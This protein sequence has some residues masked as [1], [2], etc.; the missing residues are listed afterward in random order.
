MLI[1]LSLPWCTPR[2]A[3]DGVGKAANLLR[4]AAQ[5]HGFQAMV[6]VQVG[7]HRRHRQVVVV[8]LQAGD[9]LHQVAL[10]VVEHV[11]QAGDAVSRRV[12]VLAGTLQ[13]AA[14]Q[15]AHGF[16][17]GGIATVCDPVVELVRQ[18]VVER[19]REAFHGGALR[20]SVPR[21][22]PYT[23]PAASEAPTAPAGIASLI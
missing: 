2:S 11:R 6:V 3:H 18:L 13:F 12:V 8:V 23:R 15:V 16:G 1:R 17:A 20:R 9:A 22:E 7:M 10:V 14:Q 19:D 21:S 4:R 5:D